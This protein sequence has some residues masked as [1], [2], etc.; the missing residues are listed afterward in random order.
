[1]RSAPQ[2]PGAAGLVAGASP[3]AG[4]VAL[5]VALRRRASKAMTYMRLE[6]DR[7]AAGQTDVKYLRAI[8][9]QRSRRSLRVTGPLSP[10][11]GLCPRAAGC[12]AAPVWLKLCGRANGAAQPSWPVLCKPAAQLCLTGAVYRQELAADC[13]HGQAR[14]GLMRSAGASGGGLHAL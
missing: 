14:L 1:M 2:D 5:R 4:H 12:P 6:E 9:P 3:G 10:A 8:L 11:R 7:S 13:C